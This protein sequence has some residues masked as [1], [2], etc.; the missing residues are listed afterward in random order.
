MADAIAAKPIRGNFCYH[1]DHVENK[2]EF[3]G[4]LG[5]VSRDWNHLLLT[6]N[7]FEWRHVVGIPLNPGLKHP[8]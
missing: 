4:R 5:G 1:K 6:I 3:S 2:P 7:T 8:F